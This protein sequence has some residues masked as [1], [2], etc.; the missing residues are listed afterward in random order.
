MPQASQRVQVGFS[1]VTLQAIKDLSEKEGLKYA[2]VC[3]ILIEEALVA[4]GLLSADKMVELMPTARLDF[5]P[6]GA[7]EPEDNEPPLTHQQAAAL[8][9]DETVDQQTSVSSELIRAATD[10]GFTASLVAKKGTPSADQEQS[11]PSSLSSEQL[12]MKK[13]ELIEKVLDQNNQAMEQLRQL[14][15]ITV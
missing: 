12:T 8:F 15:Q 3:S 1:E 4:R 9:K 14:G 5:L 7:I 11:Q 13:M 2:R 6:S 10:R